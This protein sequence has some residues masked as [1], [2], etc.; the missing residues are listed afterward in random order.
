MIGIKKG[1]C[2]E[3]SISIQIRC[4]MS[5]LSLQSVS[6]ALALRGT[7]VEPRLALAEYSTPKMMIDNGFARPVWPPYLRFG[8][9]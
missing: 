5:I 9:P 6:F 2:G 3:L 8:E 1:T 4:R 7:S